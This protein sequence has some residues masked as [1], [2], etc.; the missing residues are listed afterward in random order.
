VAEGLERDGRHDEAA[1]AYARARARC[2]GHAERCAT[3]MLREARE[4]ERAGDDTRALSLY[5]AAAQRHPTARDAPRALRR[6]ARLRLAAGDV[7]GA[8]A[9]LVR[10]VALWPEHGETTRALA[11]LVQ[12]YDDA[13]DL[14]GAL[15]ALAALEPRLAGSAIADNMLLERARLEVRL[16]RA[17]AAERTLRRLVE[18]HPYPA[19]AWDDALWMLADLCEARGDPRAAIAALES[20]VAVQEDAA[21]VGSYN[22][23]SFD[24]AELR[25]ARLW[26]EDLRDPAR[27]VRAAVRLRSRYPESVLRDDAVVLEARAESQRGRRVQACA[28]RETLREVDRHSRYLRP[29]RWPVPCP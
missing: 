14:A 13:G 20:M 7:A 21:I 28:L 3:T 9:L 4:R 1:A 23:G 22:L 24:D 10:V 16:G 19:G 5:E 8:R 12:S 17:V 18:A 26:L 29:G 15:A 25:I 2:G 11:L 27:A 6:A